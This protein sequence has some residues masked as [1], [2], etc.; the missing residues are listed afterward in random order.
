MRILALDTATEACSAA[1]LVGEELLER[2]EFAPRRHAALI[3]PMIDAVLAE[4]GLRPA[5]LDALA[6]GR[7]P[8]SFTGVRIAVA[9]TQGIAFALDLPVAPVSTLAAIASG[10]M[11]RDGVRQVAVAVDA[12]MGEIYWGAYVVSAAGG[13]ALEG[14][15]QVCA[16]ECT[17]VLEGH[18][19][20]GAGSGWAVYADALS[21]RT[22]AQT[23][24][25]DC[26]PRAGD[27][28]RLGALAGGR[29]NWVTAEQ[30]LPVY[31]RDTVVHQTARGG[32]L[33]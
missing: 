23:W 21:R 5:Q 18:Q 28:A 9:I 20:L 8:G 14:D 32:A 24:R 30:A 19:W 15:E 33:G 1:L 7:G 4:A 31:L 27:I 12:R 22:G 26:Y 10:V 16:P 17:P 6:F 2:Y 25:D 29:G 13:V 11:R 3:L